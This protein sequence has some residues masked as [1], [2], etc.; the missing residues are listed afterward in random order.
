LMSPPAFVTSIYILLLEVASLRT[1]LP[2]TE[3]SN[4]N[5]LS[6]LLEVG[7][8]RLKVG[9]SRSIEIEVVMVFLFSHL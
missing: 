7:K 8:T 1:E 4:L 3:S 9:K 6:P 5:S 2:A